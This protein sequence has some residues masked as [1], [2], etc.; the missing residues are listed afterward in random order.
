MSKQNCA[1]NFSI[2]LFFLQS[3]NINDDV[4]N[5]IS[6]QDKTLSMFRIESVKGLKRE[7]SVLNSYLKQWVLDILRNQYQ[8]LII[9]DKMQFFLK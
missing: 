6:G 7:T 4:S 2:S 3:S 8:N 9:I 1:H 5:V